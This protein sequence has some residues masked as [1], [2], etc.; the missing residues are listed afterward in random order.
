MDTQ[1]P[2]PPLSL[3]CVCTEVLCMMFSLGWD[4]MPERV[5]L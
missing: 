1:V 3:Q 2:S 4:R 5:V